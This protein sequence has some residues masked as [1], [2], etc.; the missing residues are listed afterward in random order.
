VIDLW[1]DRMLKFRFGTMI[2]ATYLRLV[3][4]VIA[5]PLRSTGKL[6]PK[7]EFSA[8]ENRSQAVCGRD[9]L[10]MRSWSG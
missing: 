6:Y 7:K 9:W 2:Q 3:G 4:S 10:N 8:G 1:R 5:S